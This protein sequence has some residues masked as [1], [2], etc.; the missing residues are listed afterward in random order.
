MSERWGEVCPL[1]YLHQGECRGFRGGP[2]GGSSGL[3]LIRSVW[4]S[5]NQSIGAMSDGRR[6]CMS[7]SPLF[8]IVSV[9]PTAD[10]PFAPRKT[11]SRGR[12]SCR[13]A[14]AS[15]RRIRDGALENPQ[16]GSRRHRDGLPLPQSSSLQSCCCLSLF[17][18][19]RLLD[20][21]HPIPIP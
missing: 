7:F 18:A 11:P 4:R 19:P 21:R 12:P 5:D 10:F 3:G 17:L 2:H 13:A 15:A 20:C 9:G 8:L 1:P 14:R 6:K 16:P